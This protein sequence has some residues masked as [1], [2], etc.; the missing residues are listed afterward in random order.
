MSTG[1]QGSQNYDEERS[2]KVGLQGY[3]SQ[4][5]LYVCFLL[6]LCNMLLH[7]YFYC[8]EQQQKKALLRICPDVTWIY[9][10]Q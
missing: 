2:Q 4:V 10:W 7:R 8:P 1:N 9:A 3:I 6:N 5:F